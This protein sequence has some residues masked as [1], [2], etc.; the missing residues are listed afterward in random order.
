MYLKKSYSVWLTLSTLS[1]PPNS[2]TSIFCIIC[3]DVAQLPAPLAIFRQLGR[4]LLVATWTWENAASS[5]PPSKKWSGQ[6][7]IVCD[8]C[9]AHY[10]IN[11]GLC[12]D[13]YHRLCWKLGHPSALVC[14]ASSA[15]KL[16][17]GVLKITV[18]DFLSLLDLALQDMELKFSW[19]QQTCRSTLTVWKRWRA[20]PAL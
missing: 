10:L 13:S 8:G 17:L 19:V 5:P 12:R 4:V 15:T 2:S 9:I 20:S 6:P 16:P 3:R 18:I 7:L 11:M 14:S 1:H